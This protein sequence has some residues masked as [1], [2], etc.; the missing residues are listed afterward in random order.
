MHTTASAIYDAVEPSITWN[1]LSAAVEVQISADES[2]SPMD[3]DA[4]GLTRWLTQNVSQH[5][6]STTSF[7]APSLLLSILKVYET[8][9]SPVTFRTEALKLALSLLAIIP[10]RVF[11]SDIDLDRQHRIVGTGQSSVTDSTAN[12]FDIGRIRGFGSEQGRWSSMVQDDSSW[13]GKGRGRIITEL[14]IRR[15]LLPL[16]NALSPQF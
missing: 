5:D 13:T 12:H 10:P 9:D 15:I 3:V 4:I 11:S 14:M 8:A 6:D 7:Y 2:L 16:S 1:S